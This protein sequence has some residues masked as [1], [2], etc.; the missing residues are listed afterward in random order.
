MHRTFATRP[1]AF[2]LIELLV[3]IS[4]IGAL[5]ALLLPAI[6]AA[7]EAARRVACT[8]N[9]K[10]LGVALT[11]YHDTHRHFPPGRV[12]CDDSGDTVPLA[13][14]PAGL[15]ADRKTAASGFVSLLPQLEQQSLYDQLSVDAGGLWNRN[16]DDLGWYADARK[17]EGVAQPLTVLRCSSDT[18][19]EQSD[20]Y[21]PVIAA[22]GSYAFA[23]G[24]L[25]PGRPPVDV[26]FRNNGAF[27]YVAARRAS[28][29]AD[30]LSHTY[31]V[32]EVLLADSWESSN[33]WTYALSNADCLRSTSNQLNTLPGA[34][35]AYDRQ[36]GA[37]GSQHP[38]GALFVHGD[39]H[40]DFTSDDIDRASYRAHST[41]AGGETL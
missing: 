16:V 14:C 12:G 24:S 19:T 38:G 13:L 23:Q 21:H 33:T 34:G 32:G 20:V 8:N 35:Y 5:M 36:N 30:G 39:G 4:V 40:V 15:P 27:L 3:A 28:Q 2:S 10:Q 26:K 37:F 18:S 11:N 29:V 25:G 7:R 41:I 1:A 9:L 17:R 31:F 22:T 6:Q